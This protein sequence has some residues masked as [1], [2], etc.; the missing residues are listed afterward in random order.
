MRYFL[1]LPLFL[2]L[3]L[4]AYADDCPAQAQCENPCPS[5]QVVVSFADGNCSRCLCQAEAAMQPTDDT[6]IICND[7][8][9]DG[10]CD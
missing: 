1:A 5:G 4:P 10:T 6:P 3:C 7:P 9:D 8:E 2:A